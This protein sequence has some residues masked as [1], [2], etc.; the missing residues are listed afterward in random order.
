MKINLRE[1]Q[2][3]DLALD[4]EWMLSLIEENE[5]RERIEEERDWDQV[6]DDL[7]TR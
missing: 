7:K 3:D 1:V 6:Y 2:N 5:E 4:A